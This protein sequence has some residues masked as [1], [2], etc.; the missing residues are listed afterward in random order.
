MSE[1]QSQALQ[2]W[3]DTIRTIFEKEKLTEGFGVM[4]FVFA[5]FAK[6]FGVFKSEV[7]EA[8]AIMCRDVLEGASYMYTHRERQKHKDGHLSWGII[9]PKRKKDG[10]FKIERFV[11]HM[12][13]TKRTLTTDEQKAFDRI[14]GDGD[15]MAHFI[16]N[17]EKELLN[18]AL[19]LRQNPF[20]ETHAINV[21]GWMQPDKALA[22]LRDT[23]SILMSLM[24][25]LEKQQPI[26]I[27]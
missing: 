13:K 23:A 24:R 4:S 11:D 21:M 14:K 15:H 8:V 5:L 20:D 27:S 16:E 2:I 18:Y 19:I 25:N 6:S 22:D 17:Q 9:E 10:S 26:E 1:Y 12:K 3:Q 7:F